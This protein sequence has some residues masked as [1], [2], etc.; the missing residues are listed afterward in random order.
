[1]KKI[2]IILTAVLVLVIGLNYVYEMNRTVY[3]SNYQLWVEKR[4]K[5]IQEEIKAKEEIKEAEENEVEKAEEINDDTIYAQYD[6]LTDEELREMWQELKK[7]S[8]SLL[9]EVAMVQENMDK[10]NKEIELYGQYKNKVD[11]LYSEYSKVPNYLGISFSQKYDFWEIGGI[12]VESNK[13]EVINEIGSLNFVTGLITGYLT[14]TEMDEN[15]LYYQTANEL[16]NFF[17]AL[18]E[19]CTVGIQHN[20]REI[21]GILSAYKLM[22]SDTN[23]YEQKL[24]Y[25]DIITRYAGEKFLPEKL[26][27]CKNECIY[28]LYQYTILTDE[29]IRVYSYMLSNN[30]ETGDYLNSLQL[31]KQE[32]EKLISLLGGD[33]KRDYISEEDEQ[34]IYELVGE[35]Y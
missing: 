1:M 15:N 10:Y 18:F 35:K 3:E 7:Q 13:Y 11:E 26:E 16:N 25:Q 14:A 17:A 12:E 27:T 34:E 21:E 31:Q 22:F 33:N 29:A 28:Y 30:S 32:A 9:E 20:I 23:T 6:S 19:E 5:E 8:D 2:I 4:E 24:F